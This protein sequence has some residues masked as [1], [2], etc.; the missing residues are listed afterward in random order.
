MKNTF[1]LRDH[2][3]R[4]RV[5][6]LYTSS[7]LSERIG[8]SSSYI[9]QLESGSLANVPEIVIRDI[10]ECIL[11]TNRG[12][13]RAFSYD[14]AEK[15]FIRNYHGA[16][17]DHWIQTALFSTMDIEV[18]DVLREYLSAMIESEKIGE[19]RFNKYKWA[20]V[21]L[22]FHGTH[23]VFFYPGPKAKKV[24]ELFDAECK[25][26]EY[27]LAF[28]I[29]DTYYKRNPSLASTSDYEN[30]FDALEKMGYPLFPEEADHPEGPSKED[31][32]FFDTGD[33]FAPT[34]KDF[35]DKYYHVHTQ[36]GYCLE[37]LWKKNQHLTLKQM[38][39]FL[40]NL[41]IAPTLMIAMMGFPLEDCKFYS[42]EKQRETIRKLLEVLKQ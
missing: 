8:K 5:R 12:S 15:S 37:S 4:L 17:N 39:A 26:I 14:I 27:S 29:I 3:K 1:H 2:L 25:T 20:D 21:Y 11:T 30:A 28:F 23:R 31:L 33:I 41:R 7:S 6:S 38:D 16:R 35:N 18:S 36:L 24:K 10:M 40:E 42:E 19:E 32:L 9:S 34:E 22:D 13:L